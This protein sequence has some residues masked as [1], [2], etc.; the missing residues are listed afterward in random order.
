MKSLNQIKEEYQIKCEI[1]EEL[2]TKIK[3]QEAS[4]T[5][6]ELMTTLV[7]SFDEVLVLISGK[8]QHLE[9]I[10]ARFELVTKLNEQIH[11]VQEKIIFAK[12]EETGSDLAQAESFSTKHKR[13]CHEVESKASFI[14][15]G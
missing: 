6:N 14:L 12:K 9:S 15:D 13:L 4:S 10:L 8:Q 7:T 5:Q 1:L 2:K 11:W 3:D